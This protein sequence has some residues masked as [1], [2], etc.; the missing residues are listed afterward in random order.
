[1]FELPGTLPGFI[2]KTTTLAAALNATATSF[3]VAT[4]GGFES[5]GDLLIDDEFIYYTGTAG[6]TSFTVGSRGAWNTTGGTHANGATVYNGYIDRQIEKMTAYV[7]MILARKYQSFPPYT[8]GGS[9]PEIIE[10]ICRKLTAYECQ[11]RMGILRNTGASEGKSPA[12]IRKDEA[13][14]MLE[15]LASGSMRL[16]HHAGTVSLTFG[17]TDQG[18]LPLSSDEAFLSHASILPETVV[19]TDSGTTYVFG[20]D[21]VVFWDEPRQK[22]VLRRGERDKIRDAGTAI[23][24][25]SWLKG[26]QGVTP[27][28]KERGAVMNVGWIVRGP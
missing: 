24:E 21:Y 16:P 25:Y 28:E 8:A 2:H 5:T 7:D 1:M 3:T 12:T 13:E 27:I 14:M 18:T 22:W 17:T 9:C 10:G 20:Q 11:V 6:G 26:Y 4:T 15:K 23:Y 19:V